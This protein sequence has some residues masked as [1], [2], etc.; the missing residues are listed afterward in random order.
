M[1]QV[2]IVGVSG[3]LGQ[4]LA[5]DALERGYD[6][7][8]VCREKSVTKLG[9][10]ADRISVVPGPTNDREVIRSAV[11]GCDGVLTVLVPWG[12]DHYSSGTAKAVLEHAK[13]EARLVFSCGWHVPGHPD[14]VYP[15][16]KLMAQSAMAKAMRAIRVM[17]I[18]DQV[19]AAQAIY[20][21]SARW[22][23][24]RGSTLEE[25]ESHGMPVW[26]EHVG[27]PR[28]ASDR[29][30]RIDYAAFMLEMLTDDGFIGKAPAINGR[31]TP[32]ALADDGPT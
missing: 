25:G 9:E 12:V 26:A 18:D 19:A 1:K 15:R 24:V 32:S 27:H 3:K 30:R 2:A 17:D 8:G 10:L 29:T 28:L 20:A 6:V 4:H 21:S 22:T 7:L 14:D 31:L 5:R 13:P 16:A 23:V 11:S